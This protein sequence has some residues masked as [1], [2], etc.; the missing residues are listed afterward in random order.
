M[1]ITTQAPIK[2]PAQPLTVA[3][4][5]L[6]PLAR[7]VDTLTHAPLELK[8]RAAEL[9]SRSDRLTITEVMQLVAAVEQLTGNADIGLHAALFVEPSDYDLLEWLAVSAATWQEGYETLCRYVRIL[10]EA[11]LYRVEVCGNKAH[12]ILGS[13][14]PLGRAMVDFQ[15][16]CF[17]LAIQRWLPD[18]WPELAVWMKHPEPA[19]VTAYRAMFPEARLVFRAAFNGFVYDANRLGLPLPTADVEKHRALTAEGEHL[20]DEIR[21]MEGVLAR[22]SRDILKSMEESHVD[23]ERTARRLGMTRRTLIRRLGLLG[24]SYSEL[25]KEARYRTAMHYLQETRCRVSDLAFLLGYS[26]CAPFV[27][28]FKRWSGLAPSQ[29]RRAHVAGGAPVLAHPDALLGTRGLPTQIAK[30]ARS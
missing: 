17:H 11:A 22:I 4:Q 25:V 29:Y 6:R 13:A 1:S 12:V 28:A 2:Q 24:T 7:L 5:T 21:P 30:S 20:L 10:N 16:A 19:D 8:E 14:V 15:L 3:A 23:A 26:D 18:T 9:H 27:R